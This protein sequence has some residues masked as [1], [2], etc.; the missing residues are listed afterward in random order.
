MTTVTPT[1]S[2]LP[3]EFEDVHAAHPIVLVANDLATIEA[4]R[5]QSRLRLHK[6]GE[7]L[8]TM[9]QHGDRDE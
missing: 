1:Q 6:M 3:T 8:H 9:K 5:G 2:T 4:L 7:L